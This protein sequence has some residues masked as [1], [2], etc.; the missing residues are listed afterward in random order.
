MPKKHK[1]SNR[2]NISNFSSSAT[3]KTSYFCA[4]IQTDDI[5]DF[6]GRLEALRGYL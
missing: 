2:F 4:M 3:H 5:K 1:I 6:V